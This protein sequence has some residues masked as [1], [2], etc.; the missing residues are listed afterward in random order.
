MSIDSTQNINYSKEESETEKYEKIFQNLIFTKTY[1]K[2]GLRI[3]SDEEYKIKLQKEIE[4]KYKNYKKLR[5]LDL[6]DATSS[7]E[8]PLFFKYEIFKT[9]VLGIQLA[10]RINLE[11]VPKTGSINIQ[12]I[13]QRGKNIIELTP[14]EF[15]ITINNHSQVI[16][17]Y[18]ALLTTL[19]S[20]FTDKI[21]NNFDGTVKV[22]LMILVKF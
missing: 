7:L 4:K 15:P 10:L 13:F 16:I 8:F 20:K 22:Y 9:N 12:L 17:S 5:K 21:V 14:D 2:N 11:W 18:K 3:L 19:I 1:T 6:A